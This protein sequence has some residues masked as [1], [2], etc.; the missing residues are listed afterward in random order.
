M[1]MRCG[2][3]PRREEVTEMKELKLQIEEL[4][5]RIAPSVAGTGGYD[6]SP[7]NQCNAKNNPSGSANPENGHH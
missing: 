1:G 7:G 6:G 5:A 3:N 2:V 4:E